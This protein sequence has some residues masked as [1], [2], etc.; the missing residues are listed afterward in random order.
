M[1]FKIFSVLVGTEACIASCPFCVS[2]VLPNENNMRCPEVNWRNFDIACNLANRSNVNTVVLTSR[3]EPLLFPDQ[4][5]DYLKHLQPYKFPFIELQTNGILFDKKKEIF[6]D[7]LGLWYQLG[8][9]TVCLS[10]VSNEYNKN[11]ENYTPNGTYMDLKEI[12]KLLHSIGYSV[13]LACVMCKEITSKVKDMEEF[14]LFAKSNLVEQITLRPVNEEVRR[15]SAA[16]WIKQRKLSDSDKED[17]KNYLDKNGTLLLDL[18]RLGLIYDIYGQNVMFSC[19][20]NINIRNTDPDKGRQL[21]FFQDGHLG[22]EW[23]KAGGILL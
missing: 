8:L 13:R 4:I 18:D 5:T 6:M 10:V 20:L 19:P 7:Y 23:E 1:K 14:I 16:Q 15:P 3:G 22:Y 2:G 12:I 21:I 9:T 17:I 11:Q